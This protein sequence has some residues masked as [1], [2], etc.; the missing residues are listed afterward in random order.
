MTHESHWTILET[1]DKKSRVRCV[2]GVERTIATR[3]LRQGSSRSCGCMSNALRLK[4]LEKRAA[5]A[6]AFAPQKFE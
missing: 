6:K 3:T 2:C 1:K 4:A 5:K